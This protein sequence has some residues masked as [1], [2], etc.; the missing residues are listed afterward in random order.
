MKI[1]LTED[2]GITKETLREWTEPIE[3]EGHEF[4]CF[5]RTTDTELL[6]QEVKDADVIMLANMPLPEEVL[7]RCVNL[8]YVDIAFT[9]VDH[10]AT[11]VL[12][13][14]EIPF[15]N[16]SGY[17]TEAVSELGICMALTLLRNVRQTEQ[18]ARNHGTKAG[19]VGNELRGKTAGIVGLGH[20]GSRTAELLHAFGC[21]VLACSRTVH[22]EHP[23][24]V[25]Q[26]DLN[27]LLS[28]SDI[29][30]LHCPLN[31]YTR[32]MIAKEQLERMKRTGILINLARGPVVDA[33]AL[34]EALENGKIAAAASDVFDKEPPLDDSEVLLSA[35]NM[36]LTPH[37]A[38]AT[39][40]SMRMRAK[41]VFD[42]LHSFLRGE[43]ILNE[44]K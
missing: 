7:R 25:E 16:A 26:T 5:E 44:V 14:R 3:R 35:P 8:R 12:R 36:L 38:F 24:Y 21:R 10:V 43:T 29:V 39:E 20:I 9:G 19:L 41:I 6:S 37:I 1:V 34:K 13:E 4:V 11:D 2:L 42:N 30:F 23:C 31:A 18:R 27:T 40:E 32:G 17:S 33:H 15:S 28:Q 22:P